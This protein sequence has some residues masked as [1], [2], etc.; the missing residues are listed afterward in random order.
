MPSS[1]KALMDKL[2]EKRAA[3]WNCSGWAD[4][5]TTNIRNVKSKH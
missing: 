1:S 5:G 3:Q 2:A 4:S